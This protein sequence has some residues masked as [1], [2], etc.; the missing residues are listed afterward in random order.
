MDVQQT[1]EA[2]TTIA[3]VKRSFTQGK[4]ENMW[5]EIP[6]MRNAEAVRSIAVS[7]IG[8][9]RIKYEEVTNIRSHYYYEHV[10]IKNKTVVLTFIENTERVQATANFEQMPPIYTNGIS[11]D[12]LKTIFGNTALFGE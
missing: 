1:F 6:M 5:E 12:D 3:D 7:M 10:D 2:I 4:T 9:N 11:E 8:K